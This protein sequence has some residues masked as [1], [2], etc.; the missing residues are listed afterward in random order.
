MPIVG[1][2]RDARMRLA[3]LAVASAGAVAAATVFLDAPQTDLFAS[4]LFY[5]PG[6]GFVF[7]ETGIPEAVR[8]VLDLM[9]WMVCAAAIAGLLSFLVFRRRLFGRGAATWV[10]LTVLLAVGPGLVANSLFKENWGRARPDEVV[11]FGGPK[12]FSPAL[13]PSDQCARNCSFVGGEVSSVFAAGLGLAMLA[14]R[15]R[16]LMFAGALALGAAASVIRMGQG[17]HFLSDTIFAMIFMAFVAVAAH[18]L[19]FG[20]AEARSR[21]RTQAA[22]TEPLPEAGI[23]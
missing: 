22:R 13:I 5:R 23:Q 14:E 9:F 12:I 8:L 2:R 18:W 21:A 7:G 3:V 16:R 4:A 6:H 1:E 17:A 11:E 19:V 10:F 15:R 20:P